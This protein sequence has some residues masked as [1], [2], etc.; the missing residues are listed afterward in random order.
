MGLVCSGTVSRSW[1]GLELEKLQK[2]QMWINP[3]KPHRP[4]RRGL[5]R[6]RTLLYCLERSCKVLE[7]VE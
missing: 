2:L 7:Y 6:S 4:D 1:A 5:A 3:E